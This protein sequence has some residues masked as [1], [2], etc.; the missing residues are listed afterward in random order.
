[1]PVIGFV[2]SGSA[3]GLG[4]SELQAY[5]NGLSETGFVEGQNVLIEY[6][7]AEGQ[8]DR[9]PAIMADLIHRQ[10]TVIAATTTPAALAAQAATTTI[11]IVFETG[12]DPIQLGLVAS[13]NSPGGND[14][15]DRGDSAETI[16]VVARGTA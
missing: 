15:D 3:R 9:L 7:W 5:L 4:Q 2:N 6:R 11:P 12:S 16:G 13:L 1:M 10:V 14:L 8:T